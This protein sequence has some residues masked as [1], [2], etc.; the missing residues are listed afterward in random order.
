MLAIT[1]YFAALAEKQP[2]VLVFEDLHWADVSSLEV[3][4]R[5][6]PLTDRLPVLLL[7]LARV[8]HEH[9]SWRLKLQAETDFAHRYT[10]LH[11]QPLLDPEAEHLLV[12]NQLTPAQL[13]PD[14]RRLILERSDGNPLYLEEL[15]HSLLEQGVLLQSQSGWQL[16]RPIT[17]ISIPDTLQEVLLARIDRLEE[18]VRQTLQLASVIGRSFLYSVLKAIA[19]A[20]AQLDEHLAILQRV[21]LVHE[22]N[23][24]P[25]LEY[26]FKHS[27]TQEAAYHSL[28]LKRRKAFHR[29]VGEAL[30]RLFP[31]RKDELAGL[32]AH[33]YDLGGE[34]AKA[35]EYLLAA[36]DRMR[37]QDAL[38][39]SIRYYRR[40]VELLAESGDLCIAIDVWLKLGLIYHL[41]SQYTQAYAANEQAFALQRQLASPAPSRPR[42]RHPS[43]S[44]PVMHCP[45]ISWFVKTLDP[46]IYETADECNLVNA[47]FAGLIEM[48]VEGNLVPQAARSWEVLDEGRR[49]RFHLRDDLVW[50]DGSPLTAADFEWAF[51]RNLGPVPGRY[52]E[53]TEYDPIAGARAYRLGNQ[54]NPDLVGVRALDSLTLEICLDA[55]V[56]FFLYLLA[57][58]FIFPLPRQVIEREGEN[59]WQPERI[60]SNGPFRLAA[61]HPGQGYVLE[62]NPTYFGDFQGNLERVEFHVI[63][64]IQESL[65]RFRHGELDWLEL[66][67]QSAA[68]DLSHLQFIPKYS[69]LT[70]RIF[71]YP[72]HP[73]EDRRVRLALAHSLDRQALYGAQYTPACGGC[74]PRGL[75]GHSPGICLPYDPELARRLMAEAGYPEGR[76]FPAMR[77]ITSFYGGIGPKIARQWGDTLGIDIGLIPFGDDTG[78]SGISAEEMNFQMG[79]IMLYPDPDFFLRDA[80]DNL[81]QNGWSEAP[82]EEYMEQPVTLRERAHRMALVRK[83]D[84]LLVTEQALVIPLIYGKVRWI[85]YLQPWVQGCHNGDID[86]RRI[87][88][89]PH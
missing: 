20:E 18:D 14:L 27:L 36:G 74:V 21:D 51:K 78:Q 9:G 11:L 89:Q 22:K 73:L 34:P 40:A 71:L 37:Y 5:L 69:F 77:G 48:D 25:E 28:L 33:H 84:Q 43:R 49:Y 88:I 23:R 62:R 30:E 85:Q 3:I 24:C 26:I 79:A 12:D 54:P 39:E 42:R 61:F 70:D 6:L 66:P 13:P 10:G 87:S 16:A 35:L 83:A 67:I 64:D 68:P 4:E 63:P 81:M 19:A 8:D 50:S 75:P 45:V 7:L 52:V 55:P 53:R 58:P 56:A 80:F 46:G 47:L 59:W 44:G 2:L 32:L 60:V 82:F 57:D 29:L 38:D 72:R 17:E 86:Y 1:A 31:E 76:G 41:D 15:L 65:R